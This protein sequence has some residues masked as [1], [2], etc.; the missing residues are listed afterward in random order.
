[1]KKDEDVID[2][3]HRE[4][5]MKGKPPRRILWVAILGSLITTIILMLIISGTSSQQQEK[6][7]SNSPDPVTEAKLNA[8][9]ESTKSSVDS[10]FETQ[11]KDAEKQSPKKVGDQQS[12]R[13]Q[14]Q[15]LKGA[16]GV[17]SSAEPSGNVFDPTSR[18][19][20]ADQVLA[21]QRKEEQ[22]RT[23]PIFKRGQGQS[24][25]KQSSS[26]DDELMK[27]LEARKN[28]QNPVIPQLPGEQSAK[29]TGGSSEESFLAKHQTANLAEPTS[30]LP[31]SKNKC[32]LKPGW[33]IPVANI[34]AFNS[35][36]PGE[37]QLVVRENVY[38]SVDH[39]CLAI[40]MG[41]TISITYNPAVRV[42]Q[43]RFN[44]AATVMYLP[45]GKKVP[46]MGSQA[47]DLQGAAG[48]EADVNNH[49]IKMLGTSLVLGIVGKL[50]GNDSVSTSSQNGGSTTN[51]TVFGQALTQSAQ[52]V[53]ER[54]KNITPTL[55]RD[56]AKRFNLK[57]SRE[58]WMEPYQ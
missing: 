38:D 31:R 13:D 2:V 35:D 46:M 4:K 28:G 45:N 33:L 3:D 30:I 6:K 11:E 52:T 14:L 19:A 10:A 27:L 50:S 18:D 25:Q 1:M 57:V 55:T 44:A 36:I 26:S 54:N 8:K 40:P 34:E 41:S 43:E 37:V 49:F 48:L 12:I 24:Q 47:Y 39:K 51:S 58:F 29:S 56:Q 22:I 23:S 20:N 32:F 9:E 15:A 16:S 17:P 42:G 53:L 21:K 5:V 7:A